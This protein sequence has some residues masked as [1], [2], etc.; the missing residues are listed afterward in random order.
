MKLATLKHGGR[1]G[2]LVVV[3]RDLTRCRA[4]P[5]IARTLQA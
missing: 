2:T 1:D 4:V 3:S 5:A